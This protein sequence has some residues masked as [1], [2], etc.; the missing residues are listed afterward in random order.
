[1]VE[2]IVK[3]IWY[4]RAWLDPS[5]RYRYVRGRGVYVSPHLSREEAERIRAYFAE[6][7][8]GG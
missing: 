3:I 8:M 4:A 2:R 1:L 5:M 6:E 7:D